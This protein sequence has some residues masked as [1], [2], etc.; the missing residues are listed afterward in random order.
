MQDF[1]FFIKRGKGFPRGC[2]RPG[3][4]ISALTVNN[5]ALPMEI[6]SPCPF[7]IGYHFTKLRMNRAAVVAL[8][9]VFHDDFPV[10]C[11]VIDDLLSGTK[12]CQREARET[13]R[14][15]PQLREQRLFL[16]P[17]FVT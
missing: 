3:K 8:V 7:E 11:D 1:F 16:S 9:V 15:S 6:C 17:G 13:P 4:G 12:L 2:A 14:K 5:P 10:C